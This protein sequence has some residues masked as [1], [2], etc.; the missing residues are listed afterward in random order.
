MIDIL[1]SSNHKMLLLIIEHNWLLFCGLILTNSCL[2]YVCLYIL[3]ISFDKCPCY[4]FKPYKCW[5]ISPSSKCDC[6]PQESPG[7]E[8]VTCVRTVAAATPTLQDSTSTVSM[9]AARGPSS[10]AVA[11]PTGANSKETSGCT[12]GTNTNF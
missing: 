7:P 2:I 4:L 8:V 1:C 3:L 12:T 5:R 9:S 11:A 6:W 10:S